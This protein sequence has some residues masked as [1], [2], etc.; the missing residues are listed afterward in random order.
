VG[1]MRERAGTDIS[2]EYGEGG[3]SPT[4]VSATARS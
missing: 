4:I 3:Q 1:L 2:I